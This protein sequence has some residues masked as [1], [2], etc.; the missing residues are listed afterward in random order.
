MSVQESDKL[1]VAISSRALFDL[2]DSHDVYENQG[3]EAF[4]RYQIEHENDVLAPGDAFSLV[5]KL[6]SLNQYFS[7]APKVEVILLSRNSADTG[8]RVFN[9]IEHYDLD[10]SRAAF[11]GGTSPYRYV[12]SFGCQLFLSTHAEDVRQA[13]ESGV[14]AATIM[15]APGGS[16]E[17]S[18]LRIAFDGDAVLFSD[19]AERVYK[20]EG[21]AAFARSEKEAANEPLSGGPFKAFLGAL[22]RLQAA[23]DPHECPIRTALVTARSAPA[24]ERV[25]RTLR[26]WDVRLDESLFLGGMKKGAFLKAFG[27]DVFFDDHMVHCESASEHVATGHVPHGIANQSEESAG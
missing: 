6:L 12:S 17:D 24:H 20:S 1:V 3:L 26:A 13:L 16:S 4:A 11:C 25:V 5:S 18:Q 7:D 8:L 15:P 2:G 14:A 10:I 22:H 23:L 9:S 27:A 21:L 19:E